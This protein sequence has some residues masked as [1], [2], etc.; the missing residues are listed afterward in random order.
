MKVHDALSD[1]IAPLRTD[2]TV[3]HALGQL[4]EHRVRHL[5]VID[6]ANLLAG[7]LAEDRLLR[8]SDPDAPIGTML[9]VEPVSIHP[10]EHIFDA[11]RMMVAHDLSTL[12][13]TRRGRRFAGLVRR[14]DIFDQ[15]ARMLAT[16]EPGAIL[17]LEVDP[18]DYALARLIHLIEQNDAKVRAVASQ[19]DDGDDAT[20][21]TLKLNV[22]DTARIRHVLEHNGYRIVASFGE[23]EGEF[24]ERIE[25]FMRYL[26]V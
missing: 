18:R 13:A 20:R 9:D 25:E 21:V 15:F 24:M 16:Q 3:E 2:D 19:P 5:P 1:E 17:A 26:E 14:Y 11:A 7:I 10:D 22:K 23:E 6:E 12:P 4:L 8:A